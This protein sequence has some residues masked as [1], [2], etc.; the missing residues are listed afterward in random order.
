MK[1]SSVS[2][3]LRASS[4]VGELGADDPG[5]DWRPVIGVPDDGGAI[6]PLLLL[7]CSE[8]RGGE[9]IAESIP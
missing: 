7:W 3:A 6:E 2:K 8:W 1:L 9:E 5:G 4:W